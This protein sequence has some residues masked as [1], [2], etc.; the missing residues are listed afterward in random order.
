MTSDNTVNTGASDLLLS[1][2]P[3]RALQEMLTI[4]TNLH[5]IYVEETAALNT[6]D[7]TK[8]MALQ[9]KKIQIVR[10]YQAGTAQMISRKEEFKK[11]DPAIR[12]KFQIAY[13]NF[14]ELTSANLKGID[15]MRKCV[16]RLADRIL[17]TARET[18]R[19]D[20]LNYGA[21]GNLKANTKAVSFNLNESA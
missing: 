15:R 21:S 4:I 20:S 3:T 19:K 10:Q 6:S 16:S 18:V 9:D 11:A 5:N 7:P 1:R 14:I 8:F 2:N 17:Q 13:D 12:Q